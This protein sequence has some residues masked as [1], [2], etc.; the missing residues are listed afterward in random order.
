MQTFRGPTIVSWE[1]SRC[2]A[3][4]VRWFHLERRG[5]NARPRFAGL[6]AKQ[7]GQDTDQIVVR[8]FWCA[9]TSLL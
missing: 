2:D 3:R 1:P 6:R 9:E 5:T 8:S 7:A 4:A